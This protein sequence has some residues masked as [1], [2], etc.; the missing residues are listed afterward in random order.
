MGLQIHVVSADYN[1]DSDDEMIWYEDIG[2]YG[3]YSTFREHL[4]CAIQGERA[5]DRY[6]DT[7]EKVLFRML[8]GEAK[9]AKIDAGTAH[10]DYTD[11]DG[12]TLNLFIKHCDCDGEFTHEQCKKLFAFFTKFK[13]AKMDKDAKKTY[14]KFLKGFKK[15]S[16][17]E[18]ARMLYS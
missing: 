13:N 11:A 9:R 3:W 17:R 14:N 8:T 15:A 7:V 1:P 18:G 2:P 12:V 16:E 4:V 6:E 10:P 5:G